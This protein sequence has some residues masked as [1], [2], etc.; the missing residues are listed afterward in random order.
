MV[1]RLLTVC[2]VQGAVQMAQWELDHGSNPQL[3][4]LSNSII[5]SQT[6]EI[7]QMQGYLPQLPTC[8][9]SPAPAPAAM[10]RALLTFLSTLPSQQLAA[11]ISSMQYTC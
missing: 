3:R 1:L 8:A 6:Q 5:T 9:P 4:N 2:Y 7:A 10:V 11:Q